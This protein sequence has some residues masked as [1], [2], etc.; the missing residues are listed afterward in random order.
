MQRNR[1]LIFL[2]IA[3]SFAVR[4]GN[5]SDRGRRHIAPRRRPADLRHLDDLAGRRVDVDGLVGDTDRTER[6]QLRAAGMPGAGVLDLHQNHAA[7]RTRLAIHRRI[8]EAERAVVPPG[9]RR[10]NMVH[11]RHVGGR[12]PAQMGE[13]MQHPIADHAERLM[14]LEKMGI[15]KPMP[16]MGMITPSN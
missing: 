12:G 16:K 14:V 3:E 15:I 11:L 1:I 6:K 8:V 2:G 7:V 9:R 10:V 5:R 13:G 4:D